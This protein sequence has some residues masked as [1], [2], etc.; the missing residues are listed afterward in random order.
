MSLRARLHLLLGGFAIYAVVAAGVTIYGNNWQIE[1]SLARFE[2]TLGQTT[3]VDR[4]QL[5]V[6][7][8]MYLLRELVNHQS[9]DLTS[10]TT[11][12][13]RF[14]VSLQQLT[15]FSSDYDENVDWQEIIKLTRLFESTS[16]DCLTKLDS[17]LQNEARDIY[18]LELEGNLIPKLKAQLIHVKTQ[19]ND[20]RNNS[21][22]ELASTSTRILVLTVTVGILAGV[23]VFVG[24]WLIHR[25]L[26]RPLSLLKD[27]TQ[28]Y[29]SGDLTFRTP[30]ERNDELGEMGKALNDMARA[31]SSSEQKHRTLFSNLRDA[32]VICD[33]GGRIIEYHEGDTHL[34]SVS[35]GEHIGR[36]LLDIWPEWKMAVNDWPEMLRR[37]VEDGRRHEVSNI[38]LSTPR[39]GT[40]GTYADF[41]VYRVDDG[42]HRYAAIVIRNATER[43]QLQRRLRQ[44]ET[45]EAVGTMAGGLAHDVNNLLSSVVSTLSGLVTHIKEQKYHDQVQAALKS[46]R[47]AA[48]L[49]KRLLNFARGAH[50]RSQQF[51]P[52]D[53]VNTVLDSMDPLYLKDIEVV[54]KLNCSTSVYMDQDQFAQIVLNLL[55]NAREAMPSGGK[56]QISLDEYRMQHPDQPDIERSY[57]C[58]LFQDTGV[59][60]TP[61]IEQR[62]FEPFFSTKSRSEH[63]GRG[64]GMA[65]V[66]SA[67]T[68]AEGFIR[69]ES[70]SNQ[71]TIVRV[72]LPSAS[73]ILPEVPSTLSSTEKN[74]E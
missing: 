18:T 60:M 21:A 10:Y 61:S 42:E 9:R 30:I 59:G 49:T 64:M 14:I 1:A 16:N 15:S 29:T 40:N 50:G 32:V 8:Q 4:I 44:S 28:H 26:M 51:K 54:R 31:V 7:E 58:L 57:V 39:S 37:V 45:M 56:L 46:C 71:G 63:H 35:D 25:W 38:S 22:R 53:I 23:L 20:I 3:E 24:A 6:T 68:H 62:I 2:H 47:R 48:G 13:E 41:I 27:A 73:D 19:L 11:S 69:I 52:G 34:L 12:R 74:Q 43:N 72:Y 66:H 65:I 5:L 36:H 70:E 55:S 67:V 33:E 17:P